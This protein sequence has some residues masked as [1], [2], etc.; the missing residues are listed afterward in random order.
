MPAPT[1]FGDRVL[2]IPPPGLTFKKV[3]GDHTS[4]AEFGF[5]IFRILD[6]ACTIPLVRFKTPPA[7]SVMLLFIVTPFAL[8]IVRLFKFVTLAGIKTPAEAPPKIKLE[9]AIVVR[10]PGVPAIAGPFN[11]SILVLTEKVPDARVRVPLS[12]KFAPKIISLLELKS[13]SPLAIAFNVIGAA[14]VPI[15][16]LEVTPPVND[17]PP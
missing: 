17:P 16:R 3:P 14:P 13:F 1:K 10:L 4:A 8:F 12:D 15:V 2:S 5:V 6:P 9:A 11:V 7:A